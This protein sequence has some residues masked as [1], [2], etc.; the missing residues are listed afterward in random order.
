MSNEN[1][2]NLKQHLQSCISENIPILLF[3]GRGMMTLKKE[4]IDFPWSCVMTTQSGSELAVQFRKEGTREVEELETLAQ[5]ENRMLLSRR[6]LKFV[7]LFGEPKSN[8]SRRKRVLAAE[9]MLKFIAS[10]VRSSFGLLLIIG[11][12]TNDADEFPSDRFAEILDQARQKTAFIFAS[13]VENDANFQESIESKTL[14]SSDLPLEEFLRGFFPQEEDNEEEVAYFAE[15]ESV[16][17]VNNKPISIDKAQ[18]F[19]TQGFA[20]LLSSDE[21]D[22][23]KIPDTLQR[24]YFS[25]FLSESVSRP[26]WFGYEHEFNLEREF[27]KK[28]N[29]KVESAL[30]EVNDRESKGLIVVSGQTGSSKSISLAHLAYSVYFKKVYPVIFIYD[31]NVSLKYNDRNFNALEKLVLFLEKKGARTV[32]IIWDN[33][34][35]YT[36]PIPNARYLLQGLRRRGRQCVLV[37]SA[38]MVTRARNTEALN[39]GIKIEEIETE[40]DLSEEEALQLRKKVL[41][42]GAV[43]AS[44]YDTWVKKENNK[45]LLALLY[46]LFTETLGNHIANGV[47]R[48]VYQTAE[49]FLEYLTSES[50]IPFKSVNSMAEALQ[51]AGINVSS[52]PDQKKKL[53][54]SQVKEFLKIIAVVSQF[55][56]EMPLQFALLVSGLEEFENNFQDTIRALQ[57]IPFLRLPERLED[58]N[59]SYGQSVMFRTP[60]EARL[61]LEKSSNAK[62]EIDIVVKAIDSLQEDNKYMEARTLELLI[63]MMGPNSPWLKSR[64]QSASVVKYK[65]YYDC[66]VKALSRMRAERKV[67]IPRLMCQEVCWIR[68]VYGKSEY[69]L[70]Q[71]RIK[72]LQEAIDISN[73]ALNEIRNEKAGEDLVTRNN[74]IVERATSAWYIHNLLKKE[75]NGFQDLP[76]SYDEHRRELKKV[77]RSAPDNSYAYNALMKLFIS[78]YMAN[79]TTAAVSD[80]SDILSI[81]ESNEYI[82]GDVACNE[83]FVLHKAEILGFVSDERVKEFLDELIRLRNPSGLYLLLRRRLMM[84]NIDLDTQVPKEKYSIIK[85]I[86]TFLNKNMDMVKEHEVCLFTLLR[87][88]WQLFNGTPI[89]EKEKQTTRISKQQWEELAEISRGVT[90][91][92]QYPAQLLYIFSLVEAQV[93]NYGRS[94]AYQKLL[95]KA[96]WLPPR[97]TY[98]WHILSEEDGTPRRFSGRIEK[99]ETS[100]RITNVKEVKKPK[101][102]IPEKVFARNIHSL[103]VNE[104]AGTFD[105]FEIGLNFKGFQA[106]RNL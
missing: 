74:L 11:Y 56:I 93:S 36:D 79:R 103:Q 42:F 77:I 100:L 91:G 1:K 35:A 61:Y 94:L 25:K 7:H 22:A 32:L 96:P 12:D 82:M 53:C 90:P 71:E 85:D 87:L 83:E 10:W 76:Y 55:G 37:C 16:L 3:I 40:I 72:K 30:K 49:V 80:L 73:N 2:F 102:E 17:F 70:S 63:R 26:M 38:Y 13:P 78:M 46:N 39:K 51:R 21:M 14:I 48:E 6:Q 5:L 105:D 62:E 23:V 34:S 44:Y 24:A 99:N 81:L 54:S 57:M 47:S 29:Q 41:K 8:L 18:F 28:L 20:T 19:D 33:S 88:K 66:I 65:S 97:S 75:K 86:I 45:N 4:I 89:F 58:N 101:L 52:N 98:V 104:A 27:E 9:T 59:S 31:K 68:E 92:E 69:L 64:E 67:Y 95:Q 60:L 43:E 50:Q 15:N 106:F 84:E